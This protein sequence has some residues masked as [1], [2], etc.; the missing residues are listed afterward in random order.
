MRT[1]LAHLLLNLLGAKE[2]LFHL[3]HRCDD[4]LPF[5][6]SHRPKPHTLRCIR[7]SAWAHVTGFTPRELP[8]VGHDDR[9]NDDPRRGGKTPWDATSFSLPCPRSSSLSPSLRVSD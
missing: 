6:F 1:H 2:H 5:L 4:R 9:C 8:A 7:A 3:G